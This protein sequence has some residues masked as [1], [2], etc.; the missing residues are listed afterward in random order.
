MK[1]AIAPEPITLAALN[2][3]EHYLRAV[4]QMAQEQDVVA[5]EALY[6]ESGIKLLDKG[7]RIDARLYDRLMQHRLATSIDEHLMTRDM[8]DI[9]TL[10][11]AVA[12]QA[13]AH[14]LGR[15]LV[16]ALHDDRQPLLEPLRHMAWPSQA[17]FKLTVM[18][19]QRPELYEHSVLTM[20]AAVFLGTRSGMAMAQLAGLAA[21]ALLHD[22]GML[23]MPPSW[24]DPRHR[25]TKEERKHLAAHSITAMMLVRATQ[26]FG[27]EV[28]AAVLEH[29]ERMDGSGYPRSLAGDAISP[30]GQVL[31][32]AEV[33]S[34]FYAKYSDMPAQRLSLMLRM[35]HL[36]FPQALTAHV[37]GMMSAGHAAP[38]AE[39][40]HALDEVRSDIAA[41][42]SVFQRWAGC[43]RLLPPQWQSMPG[44]R[45]C[46]YVETRLAALEKTLAEAGSHPRQQADWLA[47]FDEEPA[48]MTELAL[49][50]REALWQIDSIVH[51]CQR[52]WP[53]VLAPQTA[54][55][56]VVHD[57]LAACRLALSTR[58]TALAARQ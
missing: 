29:H 47:M 53:Q 49:I 7:M 34:A 31:L 17:S 51:T 10:E 35:N 44:A 15:Q 21:G 56:R 36:G 4:T 52:R 38:L 23:Y 30:M 14:P 41:L 19:A 45:A 24:M 20:M 27:P 50:N 3:D 28:E 22:A 33:V 1:D 12:L 11:A 40:G 43:R 8:V 54:I 18:R 25:L 48:S 6:S 57:W 5:A 58:P 2:N 26:A 9:T 37:F 13:T 39:G 42:A 46:V 16:V 32:V 55:D